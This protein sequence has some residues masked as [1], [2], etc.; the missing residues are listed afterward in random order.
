MDSDRHYTTMVFDS[1]E[2][3][4]EGYDKFIKKY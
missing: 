4:E 3:T 2:Y 1:H